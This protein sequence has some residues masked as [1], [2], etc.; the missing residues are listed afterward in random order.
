MTSAL[1]NKS[2]TDVLRLGI[3]LPKTVPTAKITAAA[4]CA[5]ISLLNN[6]DTSCAK[7]VQN[8]IK[9]KAER[10]LGLGFA[11]GKLF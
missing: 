1:E 2:Q 11:K 8:K 6:T 10:L 7:A 9:S 4:R 3:I 5:I